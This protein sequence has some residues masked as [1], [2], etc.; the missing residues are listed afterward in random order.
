MPFA[1]QTALVYCNKDICDAQDQLP[2]ATRD[3][4]NDV[5]ETLKAAGITPL[6]RRENGGGVSSLHVLA[7]E[8]FC[9]L[10]TRLRGV[11]SRGR[12]WVR[13][14]GR[15]CL[16]HFTPLPAVEPLYTDGQSPAPPRAFILQRKWAHGPAAHSDINFVL[17]GLAD[18]RRA[19]GDRSQA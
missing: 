12:F 1:T 7:G 18:L 11:R 15:Q 14:W 4:F 8:A 19:V 17:P 10:R 6:A 2:P 5:A 16:G 13:F 9:Q 3:E